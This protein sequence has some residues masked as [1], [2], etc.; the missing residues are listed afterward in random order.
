MA[1]MSGK[2]TNSEQGI[3]RARAQVLGQFAHLYR[4]GKGYFERE[5]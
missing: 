2:D 3:S 1:Q 5:N 4:A